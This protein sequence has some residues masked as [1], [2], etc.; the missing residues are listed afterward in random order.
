MGKERDWVDRKLKKKCRSS[1]ESIQDVE[2]LQKLRRM[3]SIVDWEEDVYGDES[4]FSIK[5]NL[6]DKRRQCLGSAIVRFEWENAIEWDRHE[7]DIR[8]ASVN[9]DKDELCL[10]VRPDISYAEEFIIEDLQDDD[11]NDDGEN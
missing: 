4:D 3:F 8:Y 11:G 6:V 9:D 5:S 1:F 2:T 10:L 7:I